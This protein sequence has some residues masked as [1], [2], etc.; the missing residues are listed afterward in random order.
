MIVCGYV[1]EL[2]V[3]ALAF[4][5]SCFAALVW[6]VGSRIR[7]RK[8]LEKI[9]KLEKKA[10]EREERNTPKWTDAPPL[11]SVSVRSNDFTLPT[12]ENGAE[13]GA[14]E[15][16]GADERSVGGGNGTEVGGG[17]RSGGWRR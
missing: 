2:K 3:C 10:R 5:V 7:E 12:A 8:I 14:E 15:L 1:F 11:M 9:Q 16:Q 4:C 17:E 6:G 13:V